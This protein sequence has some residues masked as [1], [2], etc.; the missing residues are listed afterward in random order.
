MCSSDLFPSHDRGAIGGSGS[1]EFHVLANS[2]ED[3]LVVCNSCDY[4]ANIEAAV[5]KANKKEK[6]P[7]IALGKV[8]TPN[9]KSIEEVNN[10]L[11]TD[12]YFSMK[13]VIKK[14]YF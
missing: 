11:G 14:S 9:Q 2:G 1:K 4:G 8:E 13:A 10:F 12:A 6:L 7:T 5:R 3:T